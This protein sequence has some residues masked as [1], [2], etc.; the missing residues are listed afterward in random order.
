MYTRDTNV[1]FL[2]A[3]ECCCRQEQAV[4]HMQS[5][6]GAPHRHMGEGQGSVICSCLLLL[7]WLMC[8]ECSS[9]KRHCTCVGKS[10]GHRD[11]THQNG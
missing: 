1:D 5:V 3:D 11:A 4:A 6:K 8:R 10:L 9:C 2:S 7:W